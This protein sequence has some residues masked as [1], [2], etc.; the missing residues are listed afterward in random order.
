MASGEVS[1]RRTP[2]APAIMAGRT[3]QSGLDVKTS[4][5]VV[6]HSEA[7]MPHEIDAVGPCELQIDQ[8]NVDRRGGA[9]PYQLGFAVGDADDV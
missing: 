3:R 8:D 7:R 4:V 1:F 5:L 9:E 6:G 2:A